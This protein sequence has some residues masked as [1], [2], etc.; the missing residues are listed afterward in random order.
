[1]LFLT[2]IRTLIRK[3]WWALER[4]LTQNV[5]NMNAVPC[6]VA[7]WREM[8][9]LSPCPLYKSES[10]DLCVQGSGAFRSLDVWEQ[11]KWTLHRGWVHSNLVLQ[12]QIF[13]A[14]LFLKWRDGSPPQ[15]AVARGCCVTH[16]THNSQICVTNHLNHVGLFQLREKSLSLSPASH[17]LFKIFCWSL[18]SEDNHAGTYPTCG[19]T[20]R[21]V[22][23]VFLFACTLSCEC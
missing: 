4:A 18:F 7:E 20:L 6:T 22:F 2:V 19:F 13:Y 15:A 1:M 9:P 5:G 17:L 21:Y 12:A 3:T 10:T 23:R 11:S 8:P 14:I 16:N